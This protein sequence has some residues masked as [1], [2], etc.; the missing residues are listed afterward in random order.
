MT[1]ILVG[2]VAETDKNL[3]VRS[4]SF[5]SGGTVALELSVLLWGSL[6]DMTGNYVQGCRWFRRC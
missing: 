4:L 1:V 6:F 3:V 5:F 2:L